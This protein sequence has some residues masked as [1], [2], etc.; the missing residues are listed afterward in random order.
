MKKNN[1]QKCYRAYNPMKGVNYANKQ[2]RKMFMVTF[3]I[4]GIL[5]LVAALLDHSL[6]AAA[7]SGVTF[8][9]M[10][11]L[12]HVDDVS[13][14]DT[15]GSA[16]SYIVYLIALDQIDRTKEFPQPKANREVAPIP[17]CGRFYQAQ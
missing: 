9:S 7:G 8:A 14:R 4:F 16:I 11:L 5:M 3:A 10:A 2:A 17:L 12:G 13:D 1:I 15:H 6:G